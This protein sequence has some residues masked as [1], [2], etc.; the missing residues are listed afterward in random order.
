M[1]AEE[2][3][4]PGIE[5]LS[6]NV[7]PDAPLYKADLPPEMMKAQLKSEPVAK[8]TQITGPYNVTLIIDCLGR[9][10]GDIDLQFATESLLRLLPGTPREL[11]HWYT[12]TDL[13]REFMAKTSTFRGTMSHGTTIE[14]SFDGCLGDDPLAAVRLVNVKLPQ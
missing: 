4:Q 2:S 14:P 11:L 6:Q 5:L 12:R 8:A 10:V 9:E 7:D 13:F 1:L 3:A